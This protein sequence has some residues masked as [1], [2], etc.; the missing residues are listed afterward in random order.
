M[1]K[2]KAFLAVV[3]VLVFALF[4][5]GSGEDGAV[6]QGDGSAQGGSVSDN[7][8]GD[9]SVVIDSCR[10]AKD[11]EGKDIVIV[12]Y[13][14]TNEADDDAAAFTFA[15]NDTVYQAGVGLNESYFVADS[16]NYDSANQTKEIKKARLW[17][18]KLPMC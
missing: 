4:A 2:A 11:Y 18:W 17:M 16:A 9:Y 10:L 8:L 1:K 7:R 14:F 5:V 12:K 15:I 3:L 13:K 6:N